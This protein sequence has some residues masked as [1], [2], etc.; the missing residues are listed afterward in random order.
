VPNRQVDELLLLLLL[1]GH[2][3]RGRNLLRVPAGR[4]CIGVRGSETPGPQLRLRCGQKGMN[5]AWRGRRQRARG[6]PTASPRPPSQALVPTGHRSSL[7]G[8]GQSDEVRRR[9]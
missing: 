1:L 5:L 2:R 8:S 7:Q 4:R 6:R 9:A 3:T